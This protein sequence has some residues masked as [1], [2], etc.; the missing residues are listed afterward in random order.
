M[1]IRRILILLLLALPAQAETFNL[2]S[3]SYMAVPPPGW[4]GRDRLPLLLFIHGYGATPAIIMDEKTVADSAASAGALLVLPEGLN[5]GWSF[6]G[7]PRQGRDDLAFLRDVLND[8]RGRYPTDPSRIVAS[9]FS[10]GA[11][12]V[13]HLACTQ[14]EGYTAFLAFSGTFWLPYP[15]TCPAAPVP[16]RHVHGLNDITF[17]LQG[18]RVGSGAQQGDSRATLEFLRTQ[19]ACRPE[20]RVFTDPAG[21]ICQE[22]N[23]CAPIQFCMNTGG[24]MLEDSWVASSFAWALGPH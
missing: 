20:P 24:H 10:I 13:W 22:W 9:G 18:R 12:M 14:S 8:V 5:R 1:T 23:G 3:G 21:M 6:P 17:P 15:T 7:S 2:P 11:T 16:L 19:R 4:N